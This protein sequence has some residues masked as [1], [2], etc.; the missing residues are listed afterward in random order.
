MCCINKSYY[1]FTDD[2]CNVEYYKEH[3]YEFVNA[4]HIGFSDDEDCGF[5]LCEKDVASNN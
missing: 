1:L 5:Y 2:S 3:G 4:T